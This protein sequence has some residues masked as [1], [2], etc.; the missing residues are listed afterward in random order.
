MSVVKTQVKITDK[1]RTTWKGVKYANVH[2][3][4]IN[5]TEMAIRHYTVHA[6]VAYTKLACK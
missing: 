5:V 3:V 2:F 4:I 6:N 1:Y